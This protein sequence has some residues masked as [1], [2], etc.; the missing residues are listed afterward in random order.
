MF[1]NHIS[2]PPPLNMNTEPNVRVEAVKSE[3]LQLQANY[4]G[5]CYG[6]AAPIRNPKSQW[7]VPQEMFLK[8][9][10][11]KF[12][13]GVGYALTRKAMQCFVK[14]VPHT[15]FLSTEDVA[16][17]VVMEKCHIE[18]TASQHVHPHNKVKNWVIAHYVQH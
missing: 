18:S 2:K 7:Y 11:P 13:A 3:V 12:C 1:S 14:T 6:G 8:N 4:W 5:H 16:T 15:K 9:R 10:F 17:G